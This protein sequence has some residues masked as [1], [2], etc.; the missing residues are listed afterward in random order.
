MKIIPEEFINCIFVKRRELIE[1]MLSGK[2][3]EHEAY[4]GL[5][6]HTPA[7]TTYGSAGLNAS[8]KG[9]V[10]YIKKNILKKLF[11]LYENT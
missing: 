10:L 11:K 9:I 2:V 3:G 4:L 5:L 1:K 7:I 6:K 8:V